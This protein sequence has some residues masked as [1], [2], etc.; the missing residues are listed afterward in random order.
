MS[1]V[2]IVKC[3]G[4]LAVIPATSELIKCLISGKKYQVWRLKDRRKSTK[5][6]RA[7]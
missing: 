6:V 7:K 1:K 4:C 5:K 2:K 3:P